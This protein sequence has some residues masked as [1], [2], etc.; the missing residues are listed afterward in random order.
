M[1]GDRRRVAEGE[2]PKVRIVEHIRKNLT[3]F[4]SNREIYEL[5]RPFYENRGH[6][7]SLLVQKQPNKVQINPRS[8][9]DQY[10]QYRASDLVNYIS[11]YNQPSLSCHPAGGQNPSINYRS[12]RSRTTPVSAP[13]RVRK[14]QES[15]QN[16]T[17]GD[18][19]K[20]SVSSLNDFIKKP[21]DFVNLRGAKSQS[22]SQE[23]STAQ[24]KQQAEQEEHYKVP[25]KQNY[26][27][28]QNLYLIPAPDCR[29]HIV[30]RKVKDI[31]LAHQRAEQK[32]E[33]QKSL[34]N[35]RKLTQLFGTYSFRRTN[36]SRAKPDNPVE[37]V[38]ARVKMPSGKSD[39]A[40]IVD[41]KDG[42]VRVSYEPK[43]VGQHEIALR[44]NEGPI[45]ESPVVF[46]VDAVGTAKKKI[47]AYG[48]GLTHGLVG[49]ACV[50]TINTG[51]LGSAKVNVTVDGP[52]T[53]QVTLNDN[54]D[55]TITA[56]Y[57]PL[58]SGKYEIKVSF[59]G[60]QMVGSPFS[61]FISDEGRQRAH[62][63]VSRGS[64]HTLDLKIAEDDLKTLNAVIVTP[65]GLEEPCGLK[66]L[67]N[68]QLA[69]VFTPREQGDHTV[70]V[71]RRGNHING[72]PFA[73]DV[74]VRDIGDAKQVKVSG[75]NVKEGKTNVDNE[76]TI[77]T[78]DAG[79]G[80]LSMSFEGPGRTELST[81][82]VGDGAIKML[83]KPSEPGHYSLVIKYADHVVPG[84]PF[85]IKVTGQGTNPQRESLKKYRK[86]VELADVNTECHFSFKMPGV[87]AYDLSARTHSPHG[88]SDDASIVDKG[89][90]VY[91]VKFVP[92]EVGLHS[93]SIRNKDIHIPG[94]PFPF[95]VGPLLDFGPHKV[96]C[97]GPG[98]YKGTCGKLNEFN[99]FTREAGGGQLNVIIEGPSKPEMSYT[100][101]RDGSCHIGY[102]VAEPGE[103][104]VSVLF[105]DQEVPDSPF[106]AYIM[107][108][109]GDVSKIELGPMPP[110][111]MIQLNKPCNMT[112][113]MNGA[114]GNIEGKVFLPSGK[115]EEC[116]ASPIDAENWGVRFIPRELG[117]HQVHIKFN[118]GSSHIPQSP[119]L[120]RV[121]HD[122]ADPASVL[123][124]GHG[125]KNAIVN[126][127]T[128]FTIETCNAG[129]AL[130][131]V[132]IEGPSKVSMGCAEIDEG[133][134][135]DY[136]P[137]A[138]GDY[139][140]SI[141]YNGCHI[142]SSPFKVRAIKQPGS[143][144]VADA[145]SHE[146]SSLAIST[147]DR[148]AKQKVENMPKFKSDATRVYCKGMGL[149]K[150]FANKPNTLTVNC[151]EAGFNMLYASL[152]GPTRNTI[153]ECSVKHMGGSIY[154]V[155]YVCKDRGDAMLVV[156]YGDEQIPGSPFRLECV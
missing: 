114:K 10:T 130:L 32:L 103:Y 128:D 102:K 4:E 136:T 60:K 9:S 74:L 76:I 20:R 110:E 106:R 82:E 42:T 25:V 65:C 56:S 124:H 153:H 19:L 89:D 16:K 98:L 91:Q 28:S 137:L 88:N 13:G 111:S 119:V 142:G 51:G 105:N 61:T 135:V 52:S 54:K 29:V 49:R 97:G 6:L 120:I 43:E 27:S 126:H 14:Q 148:E 66:V 144:T 71:K 127:A 125:L 83:Y 80:G 17:R 50:F 39:K 59:D 1:S 30:T 145:G 53:T 26:S 38:K 115:Q 45:D 151:S 18:S 36:R 35:Q 57:L 73:F 154:E 94:S 149:K 95:T 84:S 146:I 156:K 141:K 101:R 109:T 46:Y 93:I 67:K 107:P 70:N 138:P 79:Y 140:I 112:V 75:K 64:E 37:L 116:F 117:I 92:K 41:N 113:I 47:T 99:I 122:K 152:L 155:K 72:S 55:G 78:K 139:F 85:N 68:G 69:I 118:K 40:T 108:L 123:A 15:T 131:E 62:I 8:V 24:V 31:I 143:R 63:N 90:F 134:K 33:A 129:H 58:V 96:R 23:N 7:Q 34:A 150:A 21:L 3:L 22:K 100:D 44:Y 77:N 121:G 104:N 87:S 12:Q 48:P 81:K 86:E 2:E 11:S 5:S 132:N 147:T 133:Y